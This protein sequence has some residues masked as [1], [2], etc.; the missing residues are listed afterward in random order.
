MARPSE[1]SYGSTL[2]Q[3]LLGITAEIVS[4]GDVEGETRSHLT[5]LLTMRKSS[6]SFVKSA[7]ALDNLTGV[8]VSDRIETFEAEK[9]AAREE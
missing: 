5:K 9:S 8:N 6:M 2:Y 4:A 3:V 1:S 7:L